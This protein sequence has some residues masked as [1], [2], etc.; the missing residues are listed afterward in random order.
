MLFPFQVVYVHLL[1]VAF[2]YAEKGHMVL[3]ISPTKVTRLPMVLS[4]CKYPSVDILKRIQMV[5]LATK[6]EYLEFMASIHTKQKDPIRLMVVDDI[7]HYYSQAEK[8][9]ELALL[10]R[11]YTFLLDAAA[12][13]SQMQ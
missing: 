7:D 9:N 12:F 4:G 2:Q 10:A 11:I 6:K 8:H 5:Y 1:Q 13:L 3:F